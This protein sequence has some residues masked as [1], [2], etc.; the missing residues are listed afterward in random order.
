MPVHLAERAGL[1][2][3]HVQIAE[4]YGGGYPANVEG[5]HHLHCLVSIHIENF[6]LVLELT[7]H[8][9][10]SVNLCIITSN[11]TTLSARTNSPTTPKSSASTSVSRHPIHHSSPLFL[12]FSRRLCHPFP[13]SF[14][15][16]LLLPFF[17]DLQSL[18]CPLAHC[19]DIIRQQLMCI[20]D[21]GVLGRVWYNPSSPTPFPDF[22]TEHKCRNYEAVRKW[23]EQH[24]VVGGG[25][26]EDYLR[27][28]RGEDVLESMP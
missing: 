8:R 3:D 24:Q 4:K 22:N 17:P 15:R 9:I 21:I 19:L 27:P 20:V 23:A 25:E 13:S 5:L 7:K 14:P 26:P 11:I 6:F 12:Y 1:R 16:L 28:P 2:P 10:S 18:T